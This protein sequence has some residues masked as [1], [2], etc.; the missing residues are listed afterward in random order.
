MSLINVMGSEIYLCRYIVTIVLHMNV[1]QPTCSLI[2]AFRPQFRRNWLCL[3]MLKLL[4]SMSIHRTNRK[5]NRTKEKGIHHLYI[6]NK[7]HSCGWLL[8]SCINHFSSLHNSNSVFNSKLICEHV[9]RSSWAWFLLSHRFSHS[10]HEKQETR[11]EGK[12][13]YQKHGFA[14]I[15]YFPNSG[16]IISR[17]DSNIT[18]FFEVL[19]LWALLSSLPH[20]NLADNFIFKDLQS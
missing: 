6:Q 1:N 5:N 17:I 4:L 16:T 12:R 8:N 19:V 13:S 20:R 14:Y 11:M 10:M 7:R 9:L 18:Q 2:A 3:L 15:E